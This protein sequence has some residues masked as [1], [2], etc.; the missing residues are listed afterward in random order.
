MAFFAWVPGQP[1]D[2]PL[3]CGCL[4]SEDAGQDFAWRG[5]Q[6]DWDLVAECDCC[7]CPVRSELAGL[8]DCQSL[9]ACR[10]HCLEFLVP[11]TP[12]HLQSGSL[13]PDWSS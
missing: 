13:L 8:S 1:S 9:T 11:Q 7:L 5:L 10:V 12:G 2:P 4:E 3:L 6:P